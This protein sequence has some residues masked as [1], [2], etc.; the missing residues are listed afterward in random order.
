MPGINRGRS[1][2]IQMSELNYQS[3]HDRKH[4]RKGIFRKLFGPSQN[5]IWQHVAAGVGGQFDPAGF[6]KGGG[7][8]SVEV[9]EWTLTL[10]TYTVSTGKSSVTF[11]RMR[12]PYVNAD[13]FR[14]VVHRVGWFTP[15]QKLFGMQDIEIGQAPFDDHF[16][17]K[18]HEGWFG[19][20]F[21][22][23]VDELYFQCIGVIRD[24][25]LL[26]NLF[27]LFAYTLDRLCQMGSAYE[28][29]PGVKL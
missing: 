9:G 25:E 23:G 19:A 4:E 8:I 29:D 10:D 7:K 17:V 21:P 24:I 28:D 27:D 26:H 13:G 6:W 2:S 16:V 18:H 12:A 22:D 14:F 15:V 5:E 1:A 20:K 3:G 11:T